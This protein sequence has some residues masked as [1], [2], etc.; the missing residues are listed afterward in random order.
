MVNRRLN[1]QV[2]IVKGG[3]RYLV[4][5]AVHPEQGMWAETTEK[6]QEGCPVWRGFQ[7]LVRE[8]RSGF[9][10]WRSLL[11]G[12][13][14]SLP[15]LYLR[16]PPYRSTVDTSVTVCSRKPKT[17]FPD[18]CYPI[19]RSPVFLRLLQLGYPRPMRSRRVMFLHQ[20][21]NMNY[22]LHIEIMILVHDILLE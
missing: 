17:L 15:A 1:R 8:Y 12:P 11:V 9:R 18:L 5:G 7:Q 20:V 6:P 13:W 2:N 19:W 3:W 4:K 10:R 21:N 16:G 14:S 22:L